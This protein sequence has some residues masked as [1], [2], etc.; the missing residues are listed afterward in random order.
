MDLES[1]VRFCV[2]SFGRVAVKMFSLNLLNKNINNVKY[3]A[4]K[5]VNIKKAVF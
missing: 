2:G 5:A 3:Q 4:P 1:G